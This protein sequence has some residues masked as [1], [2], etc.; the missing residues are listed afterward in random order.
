M[1][2]KMSWSKILIFNK[3]QIVT[4][5]LKMS[6]SKILMFNKTQIAIFLFTNRPAMHQI[7]GF[8]NN[9]ADTV[10]KTNLDFVFMVAHDFS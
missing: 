7:S 1:K 8:K 3:T 10:P 4:M 6:W 5:K 9:I 2:L